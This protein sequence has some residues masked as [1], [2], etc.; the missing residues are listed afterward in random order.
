MSEESLFDLSLEMYRSARQ[1]ANNQLDS[2]R[3][4]IHSLPPVYARYRI[5]HD[6]GIVN[7]GDIIHVSKDERVLVPSKSIDISMKYLQ[8]YLTE[9]DDSIEFVGLSIGR[10]PHNLTD[11]PSSCF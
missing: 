8:S 10:D 2:I 3:G 7:R 5:K 4:V 1:K 9:Q 11:L 6:L